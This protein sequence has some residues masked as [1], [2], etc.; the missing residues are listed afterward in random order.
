[1]GISRVLKKIPQFGLH[2]EAIA[3]WRVSCGQG[4]IGGFSDG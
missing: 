4:T 1:M 3:L 2:G